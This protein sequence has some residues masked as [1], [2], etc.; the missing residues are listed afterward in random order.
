MRLSIAGKGVILVVLPLVFEFLFVGILYRSWLITEAQIDEQ[1]RGQALVEQTDILMRE[2]I[3]ASYSIT[4]KAILPDAGSSLDSTNQAQN[5]INQTLERIDN[6]S[7]YNDSA[8]HRL[9]KIRDAIASFFACLDRFSQ[10]DMQSKLSGL[11]GAEMAEIRAN[12][13]FVDD[14]LKSF[15]LAAT[16]AQQ[17]RSRQ[18]I[19]RT[20]D[21]KLLLLF[22]FFLNLAITIGLALSFA[23]SISLRLYKLAENTRRVSS[24]MPTL[25]LLG[26]NDELSSLDLVIHT[27][28]EQLQDAEEQRKHLNT[29]LRDRLKEPLA[30][31]G[32]QLQKLQAAPDLPTQA[33]GKLSKAAVNLDRLIKLLNDLTQLEEIDSGHIE[34]H[35]SE[36][37]SGEIVQKSIES[38]QSLSS[39][40]GIKINCFENDLSFVGD[41]NRLTQVLINLLSNAIKFSPQNG[42]ICIDVIDQGDNLEFR[43]KDQGPG[44]PRE[45]QKKIFERYEQTNR[46]DA[47]SRGGAGLGLNICL[48]IAESHHGSMGVD[49]EPGKGSEFWL[50]LPKLAQLSTVAEPSQK[51]AVKAVPVLQAM[52]E[53]QAPA[54][55]IW[56]KGLI[57]VAVPLLFQAAFLL[58]LAGM[59]DKAQNETALQMR[60]MKIS[61]IANELFRDTIVITTAAASLQA[62]NK[63]SYEETSY[64]DAL[65]RVLL[66][67]GTLFELEKSD[68]IALRKVSV[69]MHRSERVLLNSGKMA[70]STS[71]ESNMATFALMPARAQAIQKSLDG[72]A[73]SLMDLLRKQELIEKQTPALRAKTRE[74]IEALMIFALAASVLLS[75][76]L[77]AFF[78]RNIS[79]R[80][81]VLIDNTLRFSQSD[82]L[83]PALKGHDEL[84]EFDFDFREMVKKITESQEF[85]RHILAVVSHELRTPLTS[86]LGSLQLFQ[87]GLYG[88]LSAEVLTLLNR[89]H[90]DIWQVVQLANDLLDI[91]RIEAGKF[92]LEAKNVDL[93][94]SLR[95]A[96][97]QLKESLPA[98]NFHFD[99]LLEKPLVFADP[100]LT[101]KALSRLLVYCFEGESQ[102]EIKL[103]ISEEETSYV[104][105][106]PASVADLTHLAGLQAKEKFQVLEQFED[107][108][109]KASALA[110]ALSN[111]LITQMG[112]EISAMQCS[113]EAAACFKVSFPKAHL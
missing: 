112:G 63:G 10:M 16:T 47:T 93:S 24:R 78:S 17:D 105:R 82:E 21:L 69:L 98:L 85:K 33:Q 108:K 57:V 86:I 37:K 2:L 20:S 104:L 94:E 12:L 5:A 107:R 89:S 90:L 71:N 31:A 68:K 80:V 19:T 9:N 64:R 43:V 40:K 75:I 7:A 54:F 102:T 42:E 25:P 14:S 41:A 58:I 27:M 50:R 97:S 34:L 32:Q 56:H 38:L 101:I 3:A 26:G 48:L 36:L 87:Q 13:L 106:V 46:E 61:S 39:K 99:C 44:V 15:R 77:A 103:E 6:L 70:V 84:N 96:L 109:H 22:A 113:D 59:L 100:E 49:S 11:T 4:L 79:R 45:L 35:K 8:R 111:R 91:E 73:A 28:A 51:D 18:E 65:E 53:R 76:F 66:R 52:P 83:L 110:L 60:A 29:L 74:Q 30:N 55:R 72:L 1:L 92:P 62:N 67:T 23:R 81:A 95:S 88:S